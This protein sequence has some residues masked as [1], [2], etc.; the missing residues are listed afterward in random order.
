MESRRVFR[1]ISDLVDVSESTG[2][3]VGGGHF[4]TGLGGTTDG[5]VNL[6][7]P[8]GKSVQFFS[9]MYRFLEFSENFINK[10]I[11]KE[12]VSFRVL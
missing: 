7:P 12:I 2:K 9:L 4:E 10:I 3:V 8:E 11:A 5:V 1:E 6:P